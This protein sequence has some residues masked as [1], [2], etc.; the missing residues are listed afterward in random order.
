MRPWIPAV[1]ALFASASCLAT[2]DE[3]LLLRPGADDVTDAGP[4]ADARPDDVSVADGCG[5]G[6]C[7]DGCPDG[8][9]VPVVVAAGLAAPEWIAVDSVYVYVA[10]ATDAGVTIK[11]ARKDGSGQSAAAIATA[12]ASSP[13]TSLLATAE[14]ALYWTS[15]EGVQ[16]CVLPECTAVSTFTSSKFDAGSLASD[17]T[18]VFFSR[19]DAPRQ[20]WGCPLG[21][22]CSATTPIFEEAGLFVRGISPSGA[23][24]VYSH[25]IDGVLSIPKSGGAKR[26]I[27]KE[28]GTTS[29]PVVANATTA[30]WTRS[31]QIVTCPLSGC[32]G[33]AFSV[34]AHQA[35]PRA[36]LLDGV[37][38][39]WPSGEPG[40]K[41]GAFACP[42]SGCAI[43]GGLVT[44]SGESG[45]PF[46]MAIDE[47]SVY[48]TNRATGEIK[49]VPKL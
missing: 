46:G 40:T 38:V 24:L 42:L 21:A 35:R 3:S 29:G 18:T 16:R 23:T 13:V 31:D 19:N 14:P 30:Y 49:R 17:G 2:I 44:L 34:L 43:A 25:E 1:T 10:D 15:A 12:S 47:S 39:Y 5:G 11:R 27:Y 7:R 41:L 9:C 26:A 48:W 37:H 28:F 6:A 4:D 36:L 33:G 22:T 20:I 45:Q 8:G 32:P